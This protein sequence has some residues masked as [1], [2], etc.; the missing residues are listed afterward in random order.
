MGPAQAL[1]EVKW[2]LEPVV[3]PVKGTLVTALA[4]PHPQADLD[5]L[6]QHLKA[7]PLWRKRDSKAP[8]LLFVVAGADAEP[9]ASPREYVERG[10]HLCQDGWVTEMH[11]RDHRCEHGPLRVGGQ[12]RQ[13]GIAF[14]FVGQ[15]ATHDRV[16]PDM[17]RHADAV[18][19]CLF[20]APTDV[21][22]GP[23][24]ALRSSVPVEAVELQSEL[25]EALPPSLATLT[26]QT[27]S[28]TV[29]RFPPGCPTG[30]SSR[31][32]GGL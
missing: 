19:A 10:H 5:R 28:L 18:E 29:G 32:V 7:L 25:H 8:G 31:S 3:L 30:C 12:E 4:T 20:R 17:V 27:R 26:P 24:E 23:T 13:R 11:P 15:R 9:G 21:R 2:T 6:L 1:R 16:L 14:R 22:E